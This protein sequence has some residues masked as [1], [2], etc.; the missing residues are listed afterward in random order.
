MVKSVHPPPPFLV[1]P[2]FQFAWK[3]KISSFDVLRFLGQRTAHWF[4]SK[5][6]AQE[7]DYLDSEQ[8]HAILDYKFQCYMQRGFTEKCINVM[9]DVSVRHLIQ[10]KV[11][12]ADPSKLQN[13]DF[14]VPFSIVFGDDDFVV[15]IDHGASLKLVQEKRSQLVN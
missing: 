10:A 12:L 3:N 9:F 8:R 14:T 13:A 6:I 2:A 15:P 7:Y 5:S 4:L 1:E 11:P